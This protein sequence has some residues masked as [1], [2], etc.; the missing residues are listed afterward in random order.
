MIPVFRAQ[1]K[2][3]FIIILLLVLVPFCAHADCQLTLQWDA[4][5]PAPEGYRLFGREEGQAYDYGYFWWQGDG[6]F[7]QCT[8]TGLDESKTY[9]FTV[10]AYNGDDMSADTNEVRFN[11][12]DGSLNLS[13]TNG[14]KNS[15]FSASCFIQS[16]FP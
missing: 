2:M 10:R 13:E 16:L 12:S 3:R 8:I 1:K 5:N 4:N 11:S 7:R 14:S 6:S 9:Y 15:D